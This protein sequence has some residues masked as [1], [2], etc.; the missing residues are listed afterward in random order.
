MAVHIGFSWGMI[1]NSMRRMTGITGTNRIR[2]IGLRI[3]AVLIVVYGLHSSFEGEMGSK[4]FIY[5]PF[6]WFND[7][8]TFRFLIDHL[9]IIGIYI[10][11]THNALKFIQR[12][13]QRGVQKNYTV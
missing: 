1:I 4:L 9:S 6:G 12:K 5:N 13:E 11:G 2:T 7:H 8:S 3:L 10:A